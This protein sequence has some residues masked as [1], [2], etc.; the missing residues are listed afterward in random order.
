M[1]QPMLSPGGR[2]PPHDPDAESAVLSAV[3]L[4]PKALGR[5]API[6]RAG[7]ESFYS[8]AN[9][10]IYEA[11]VALAKVGTPI[12]VVTVAG[13]LKDRERLAEVGGVPY[14]GAIVDSVPSVANLEAYAK[15]VADKKKKRDMIALL[16]AKAAEGYDDEGDADAWCSTVAHAASR[17][18]SEG[19]KSRSRKLFDVAKGV[20]EDLSAGKKTGVPTGYA[21]F[22]RA[23]SGGPRP[24]DLIVVAGR[25]GMGKAQPLEAPVLTP[26]GWR[27]MG[28]LRVGDRV[29]GADGRPCFVTGVFPQGEKDVYRVV[30]DD[31]SSAE[32][33]DDHLWLT[34]TKADR[35]ASRAGTVKTLSEVRRRLRVGAHANHSLPFV[36]PVEFDAPAEL[37][38]DPYV[39]GVYLGDGSYEGQNSVSIHTPQ[40]DVQE[41]VAERLPVGDQTSPMELGVRIK[42]RVFSRGGSSTANALRALGLAGLEAHEKFI[43]PSYLRGTV[44]QRWWLLRGLCDTDGY[45]TD[46]SGKSIEYTTASPALRDG[47]TELAR[48]LGGRVS[49][50]EKRPTYEY[51]GEKREGRICYRL[52]VAFPA[53][54][55]TPVAAIKHLIKWRPS[56][57]RVTERYVERVEFVGRKACQCIAVSAPDHLYVTEGFLVTH[58][59]AWTM[60]AVAGAWLDETFAEQSASLFFTLEMPAAQIALRH[61]CSETGVSI[62]DMRKGRLGAYRRD[63][64]DRGEHPTDGWALLTEQMSWLAQS[65]A[66]VWLYDQSGVT[67]EGVCAEARRVAAEAASEREPD[68]P[69][70]LDGYG[71]VVA[72]GRKGRPRKLRVIAVDYIGLVEEQASRSRSETREQQVALVTRTLKNLAKELD[73]VVYALS[74]LNR[75]VEQRADKR[76][77]MS[78]LRESGAIEQ[79]ADMVAMLYRDEY[80]N[81]DDEITVDAAE[82]SEAFLRGEREVKASNRN[83]AEVLIRKFRNGE[84]QGLYMLFH[85]PTTS[86]SSLRDH[87]LL[88][89]MPRRD[90]EESEGA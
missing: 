82:G 86:F 57:S 87:P 38:L 85:G 36:G 76:P 46:P 52:N 60:G 18:A 53:G 64:F 51:L 13:W 66:P 84:T 49:C 19:V 15:R 17:V 74:Q 31:G 81:G 68:V 23:T 55:A 75:T 24:G 44:E 43:P 56:P 8:P 9:R 69:P 77:L 28:D 25:P 1:T 5:V 20:F 37:A 41:R 11:C 27:P 16:Q 2:V 80:Y 34:R 32:C 63:P 65:D 72:P 30:V 62:G 14:L 48:S 7:P 4:E 45:V 10:R 42:S 47:V 12:D 26:T 73:C 58:N 88:R 6:L 3:M 79:D 21:V 35:K 29:V 33:C 70:Q 89:A 61:L 40:V 90:D 83:I 67:I 50:A 71:N 78:D 22:D 39:L 54:G 59:T